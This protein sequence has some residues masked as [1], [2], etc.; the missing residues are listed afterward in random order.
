MRRLIEMSLGHRLVV[1]LLA[2]LLIGA[3][4]QAFRRLP[5]DAF[6]DVTNIQ[7][8]V[9]SQAATL[10]PLEIEQLVTYPIEQAVAGLPYSTEVRSL[11]KFGL[12]MV[13]VVFEDGTDIYF[14]RQLVLERIFTVADELPEGTRSNLG[15]ISTGLGEVFQYTLESDRRDLMELRSLQDWILR[16]ILRTV[17]GVAGVDSFGGYVRQFHVIADPVALRRFAL[18]LEELAAAVAAN[19]GVAGGAFV[20]RGGEQFVVRG[21]G[22]VRSMEDLEETV[23]AYRNGVPV[24]LRQVATVEAASEIRQGAISRDGR[25]ETVAGIVLMLRGGSGR[26]VVKGVKEKLEVARQSLPEDVEVV[27]FYDRDELVRTALGTVE[28]ALLQGAVLV[29]LVLLFFMGHVRSAVL[30]A[31][32]LPMAALATFLVMSLVGMSSNLMTLS[33]LAIAIG[34]LGDGAIVLVENAVRL[35]GRKDAEGEDRTELIRRAALEVARPIV[36]GIAVIIVVFLPIAT[37]QG[38]EGKMF[39]PLAYTISIALGC[40]LLLSMTLIPALASLGLKPAPVFGGGRIPHPADLVRRVYR[41]QLA[42]ALDHP[43]V[44]IGLALALLVAAAIILPTLGTE[45]LP[46]M[47]EGSIVVQPFQIPS[48]SLGQALDTVARIESAIMELPEV[49]HVVSRT[50]RSDISSDPMGVGE[51]DTYVILRP[52]SEWTTADTKAGLVD[53][54]RQQLAGI[55]GVEFG[56]TQPIQMRVDELLSGVKSQI[57]VKVFGDDLHELAEAGEAIAAV[58]AEVDGAV[59]IKVEAVE[60]LGYLEIDMDRRRLS[61]LGI[62]VASVR[63][64]IETAIGGQVV[65]TVPEG[66]R[67]T[68]VVVR[69]PRSFT[70]D[71]ENL[72]T[73]PLATPAGERVELR[74]VADFEIVEGPAQI[75][76]EDGKRR[77]VVELNVVGRDI[78]GFVAEAQQRIADEVELPESAY[79]TWGGQFEQQQRAMARLMLMVPISLVFIFILLFLNFRDSRPVFLILANIPLALVGGVFGLKLFGMYL[80]VSASVGFIALFGIA[81]LN[82]LVMVEFFRTLESQGSERRRAVL[83]GAEMRLRP[84]LMTAATTALGLLPMV[85]ASGVGSEVQRPLAVVVVFGV[86]TSTLLTLM[87][88]P[89]LYDRLGSRMS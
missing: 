14:A 29:V 76:R 63:S 1:V 71:V 55:P 72:R 65:T 30:V 87:V 42:W 56:Y 37:L 19:N 69:L 7:V 17:P 43:A 12:S 2:L 24:L 9:I 15:P 50:G 18:G 88:L 66:D 40:A 62:S 47:D 16:P 38:L 83:E 75:S 67:R 6:P 68:D 21:D 46:S 86:V 59:D 84:V 31:I 57:A 45:F 64:L 13:T 27:P 49:V 22:W 35:L 48:V 5:I 32:Q 78:G 61:R 79:T 85:W 77:V 39:A 53:A 80:S 28:K 73:L 25:G 44:V 10:S 8:T 36:F 51:S 26:D 41:P 70:A 23:V 34:M 11:S 33:G 20:E 82:G 4:W 3:G 81:I 89:V 52:R 54:I 74:E 58:L 60:G